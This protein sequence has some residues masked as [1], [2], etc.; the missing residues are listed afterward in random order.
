MA[1]HT[2]DHTRRSLLLRGTGEKLHFY[3]RNHRCWPA[4]VGL[5]RERERERE[6]EK[7]EGNE[8][9]WPILV[10]FI[11][12]RG[13]QF[14]E[15]RPATLIVRSC[16]R[17]TPRIVRFRPVFTITN[18]TGTRVRSLARITS[19]TFAISGSLAAGPL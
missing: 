17:N 5:A 13:V 6:R 11:R 9:S 2:L 1:T 14:S 7:E 16:S 19:Y 10:E 8:V 18:K 4:A 12:R 15:R 3:M